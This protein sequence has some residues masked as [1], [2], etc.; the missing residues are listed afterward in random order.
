MVSL[1]CCELCASVLGGVSETN[2]LWMWAIRSLVCQRER[3]FSPPTSRGLSQSVNEGEGQQ[4]T[5]KVFLHEE[6]PDACYITS[7]AVNPSCGPG[8]PDQ[9]VT[10]SAKQPQHTKVCKQ[11]V[12]PHQAGGQ[13]LTAL[14]LT[15]RV[16]LVTGGWRPSQYH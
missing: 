14:L 3:Q 6:A 5:D 16:S 13:G 11:E 12:I 15:L 10:L 4:G 1:A 8:T 7:E 9:T 2:S